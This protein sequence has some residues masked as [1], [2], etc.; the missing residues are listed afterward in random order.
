MSFIV[1]LNGKEFFKIELDWDYDNG[2]VNLSMEP[3]PWKALN[4]L[5]ST[6]NTPKK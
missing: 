4:Q 6:S 2:E 5:D 1:D 3:Y